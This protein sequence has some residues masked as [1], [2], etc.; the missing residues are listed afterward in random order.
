MSTR[1]KERMISAFAK[2]AK[3]INARIITEFRAQGH[4][5]TGAWEQSV[6]TVVADSGATAYANEYGGIVNTGVPADRIPYNGRTGH[7]GQSKYITG[8]FN[9]FKLRGLP[10]KEAIRAAFATAKKHSKEGMP[11]AASVQ[12]S[13]TGSRVRFL[14]TAIKNVPEADAIILAGVDAEV[15]LEFNKEKSETI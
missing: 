8:L 9:Y 15:D 11:T 7:G 1:R 3:V 10:E 2:A 12:Y 4:H 5:L 6:T 14:Q 13:K